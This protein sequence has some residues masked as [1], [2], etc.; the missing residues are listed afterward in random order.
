MNK[1]S[2][3]RTFLL[4]AIFTYQKPTPQCKV[5]TFYMVLSQEP[6]SRHMEEEG[7]D[8]LQFAFRWFN[9]LLIREVCCLKSS[10]VPKFSMVKNCIIM[11][12]DLYSPLGP[13]VQFVRTIDPVAWPLLLNNPYFKTLILVIIMWIFLTDIGHHFTSKWT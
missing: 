7:L 2:L 1:N 11:I 12:I 9:C 13:I 8:F 4:Y 6:I 5:L 10:Q 3:R